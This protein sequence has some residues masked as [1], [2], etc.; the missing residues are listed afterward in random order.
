MK[1]SALVVLLGLGLAASPALRA[2]P[3]SELLEI[4]NTIENLVDA[5]VDEGVLSSERAS[6]IKREAAVKAAAEAAEASGS[7]VEAEAP[8]AVS[9]DTAKVVRVPY[10]PEFVKEE[11]RDQ[12]RAQLREEV[13]EDVKRTAKDEKWGTP[14]ALPDWLN[15][16]TLYGDLRLRDQAEF[17]AD[18]NLPNTYPNFLAIDEAGSIAA[19]GQDAFYN[20]TLDRNRLRVRL[21]LGM[22]AR[23]SD[24]VLVGAGMST[25]NIQNPVSLNQT[26]GNMGKRFEFAIDRAFLRYQPGEQERPWL[27]FFG[28]RFPHTWVGTDL[29]WDN[30]LGMEGASATVRY[31]WGSGARSME[32]SSHAFLTVA[33][34]SLQEVNFSA[35]DKWLLGGQIGAQQMLANDTRARFALGYYDFRGITGRRNQPGSRLEDFTAPTFLQRGNSMFDIANPLA[36][37]PPRQLFALASDFDVLSVYGGMD[38]GFFAPHRVVLEAEFAENLGFDRGEIFERTGADIAPRTTAWMVQLMVGQPLLEAFGEWQVLGAYRY[39]QRD[40]VLDAFTDS[41]FGLGATDAEGFILA[42]SYG[43]SQHLWARARWMSSNEID[44]P[45]LGIDVLQIDLNA[46]F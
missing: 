44:G 40:A 21:R 9:E 10:V 14:D 16:I 20:T 8:P 18:K 43:L 12:V 11:I 34:S 6:A 23:L 15:R 35:R 24:E 13:M 37:E 5:L 32:R 46:E 33:G 39:V 3:G 2:A 36:G 38:F 31:G 1:A 30:D 26:L 7:V 45:P 29:V 25:G 17:F 41:N 4:K 22:D 42:F 28:G 27:T 19:A